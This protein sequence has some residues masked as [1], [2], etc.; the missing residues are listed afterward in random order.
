MTYTYNSVIFPTKLPNLTCGVLG[1]NC[2]FCA[3]ISDG[4]DDSRK[5]FCQA[6]SK[7]ECGTPA[8]KNIKWDICRGTIN[9]HG[10][11]IGMWFNHTPAVSR[12]NLI[13]LIFIQPI[14]TSKLRSEPN[15]SGA[16]LLSSGHYVSTANRFSLLSNLEISDCASTQR[17]HKT[18][19]HQW[20]GN[21]IP[22]IVNGILDSHSEFPSS[23]YK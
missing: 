16:N 23:T 9:S 14:I 7:W 3:H 13:Y 10:E 18:T 6:G 12:F 21:K 15:P 1:W 20:K 8:W 19:N 2:M 17:V 22:T 5:N 11:T 4:W